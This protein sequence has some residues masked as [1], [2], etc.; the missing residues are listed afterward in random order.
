MFV[1]RP[2]C[3]A[4]D[5]RKT[6]TVPH[7]RVYIIVVV[8]VLLPYFIVCPLHQS[9]NFTSVMVWSLSYSVSC[10]SVLHIV[11]G[12]ACLQERNAGGV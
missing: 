5:V 4:L 9:V 8:F 1:G 10:R 6:D 2:L 12:K 11:G 3:L 7:F